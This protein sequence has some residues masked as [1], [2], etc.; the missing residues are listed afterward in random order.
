MRIYIG[1]TYDEIQAQIPHTLV[2]TTMSSAIWHTT[3]RRRLM[4][5]TFTESEISAIYR[6]HKQ[7]YTWYLRTG[8]PDEVQMT[9]QTY[10]LW[11]RLARFCYEL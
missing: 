8:V 3:R 2:A 11:Q 1:L 7:A 5:E 6:L 9:L 4:K 10:E